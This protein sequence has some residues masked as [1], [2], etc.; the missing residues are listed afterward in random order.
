VSFDEK[1]DDVNEAV[2]DE[3][4]LDEIL[5]GKDDF[6]KDVSD[7]LSIAVFALESTLLS[8]F[9]CPTWLAKEKI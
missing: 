2:F 8:N 7:G 6:D 1:Y 5:Y 3:G 4:A 9:M